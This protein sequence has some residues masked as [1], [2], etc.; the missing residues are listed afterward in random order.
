MRTKPQFTVIEADA[1][2]LM[3]PPEFAKFTGKPVGEIR[4]K[5]KR[6]IYP[7]TVKYSKNCKPFIRILVPETLR[8]IKKECKKNAPLMPKEVDK[9]DKPTALAARTI[10]KILG[11]G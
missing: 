9:K 3:T 1:K 4:D 10:S 6:G 8:I 11:N 7:H 2:L 5:C